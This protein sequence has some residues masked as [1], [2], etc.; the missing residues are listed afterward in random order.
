MFWA[1]TSTAW[2]SWLFLAVTFG[3][4]AGVRG[5]LDTGSVRFGI[6]SGAIS[7]IFFATV[8]LLTAVRRPLSALRDLPGDDRVAVIRAVRHGGSVHDPRSAEALIAYAGELRHQYESSLARR[9]RGLFGAF[10]VLSIIVVIGE[11][12]QG[13]EIGAIGNLVLAIA[14][15]VAAAGWPWWRERSRDRMDSAVASAQRLLDSQRGP[16]GQG[17]WS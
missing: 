2:R 8:M 4:Y 12:A 14:W 16:T 6:V 9:G 11:L 5:G 10:A 7:G 3:G 13:N 1:F 17:S 15:A